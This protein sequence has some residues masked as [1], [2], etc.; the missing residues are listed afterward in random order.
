VVLAIIFIAFVLFMASIC[1]VVKFYVES[2]IPR[3]LARVAEEIVKGAQPSLGTAERDVPKSV[4]KVLSVLKRS[5][6]GK[7]APLDATLWELGNSIG[8]ASRQKGYRDGLAEGAKP[9]DK[10]RIEISLSELLQMSWLAHL[11]FQ[12]MMPNYRGIEVHRFSGEDDAREAARS[13]GILE[14][15]L[16]K[17]ERP[18]ADIKTQLLTREK[19]IGDW[20]VSKN[21]LRSA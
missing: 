5:V 14:C 17:G 3:R 11:G 13:V 19:M 9:D 2:Q 4:A 7:T 18:F 10:I 21:V 15:A 6:A 20:W 16:P 8:E 12:H 1:S